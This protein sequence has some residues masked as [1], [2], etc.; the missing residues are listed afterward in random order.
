MDKK[1]KNID[2]YEIPIEYIKYLHKIDNQVFYNEADENYDDK[3]Y[4]GIIVLYNKFNY[5][6]PLTSAKEKHKNLKKN[7]GLHYMLIHEQLKLSEINIVNDIYK[8]VKRED[9]GNDIVKKI[10]ALID[11]NKAIPVP[12]NYFNPITIIGHKNQNLLSKEFKFCLSRKET[13][14]GKTYFTIGEQYKTGVVGVAQCNYTNL[15]NACKQWT[16]NNMSIII[17]DEYLKEF[18][19]VDENFTPEDYIVIENA[20][21]SRVEGF[22]SANSEIQNINIYAKDEFGQE[23]SVSLIVKI[24]PPDGGSSLSDKKETVGSIG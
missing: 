15:Q 6:I 14:V 1:E 18:N 22:D 11:F 23:K 24:T 10:Y 7:T 21:Y 17:K 2:F 8:V 12:N 5:F 3:P 4:I 20:T 16:F 19:Y 9:D 13:I